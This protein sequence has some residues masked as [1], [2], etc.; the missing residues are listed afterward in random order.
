MNKWDLTFISMLLSFIWLCREK[1]P[2]REKFPTK[3]VEA[4]RS[5]NIGWHFGIVVLEQ[6]NDVKCKFCGKVVK[7]GITSRRCSSCTLKWK[8]G[9]LS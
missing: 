7:G 9:T 4:V 2:S 6:R 3:G 8:Y 5:A 1:V